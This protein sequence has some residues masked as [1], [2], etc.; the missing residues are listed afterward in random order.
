MAK[1]LHQILSRGVFDVFLILKTIC[2]VDY[3]SL[4]ML[5]TMINKLVAL[6]DNIDHIYA[7]VKYLNK[8]LEYVR[9]LHIDSL[10]YFDHNTILYN[11]Y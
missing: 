11:I 1:F 9:H 5:V 10:L 4:E 6:L 3:L 8:N 2:L 7:G